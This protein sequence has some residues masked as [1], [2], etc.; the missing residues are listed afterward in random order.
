MDGRRRTGIHFGVGIGSGGYSR[1]RSCEIRTYV[2]IIGVS[3][4]LI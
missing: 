1:K 3:G 4:R 2:I